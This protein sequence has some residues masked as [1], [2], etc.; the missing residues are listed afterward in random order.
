[1]HHIYSTETARISMMSHHLI[2]SGGSQ[3]FKGLCEWVI[4]KIT[5]QG[6]G[7]KSQITSFP[8][9]ALALIVLVIVCR[10]QDT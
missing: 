5:T 7:D 10:G 8:L 3:P 9:A 2:T 1:M 6:V 4:D